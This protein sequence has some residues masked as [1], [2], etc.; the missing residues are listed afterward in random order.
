LQTVIDE[1]EE[2]F[3]KDHRDLP[4]AKTRPMRELV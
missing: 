1:W 2:V 4:E 3:K